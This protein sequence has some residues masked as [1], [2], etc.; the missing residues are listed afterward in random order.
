MRRRGNLHLWLAGAALLA[1]W[2]LVFVLAAGTLSDCGSDCGDNGGRGAFI[3]LVAAAPLGALA[4]T[5]FV[6]AAGDARGPLKLLAGLSV[7]G[8]A[9]VGVVAA[10]VLMWALGQALGGDQD[11]TAKGAVAGLLVA[12]MLL[13]I[14]ASGFLP[15]LAAKGAY[16]RR[17]ARWIVAALG[18]VYLA[19]TATSSADAE[20]LPYVA[21]GLTTIAGA[22]LAFR[23]LGS[24][25]A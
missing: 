4:V 17:R 20:M 22:A 2:L 1:L 10:V 8:G 14:A 16:A 5:L 19:V 13:A 6:L 24:P 11:A 7:A 21:V 25:A 18:F 15:L 3:G 9:L 12:S 23:E